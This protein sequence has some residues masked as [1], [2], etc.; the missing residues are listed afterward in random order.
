[1]EPNDKIEFNDINYIDKTIKLDFEFLKTYVF[2]LYTIPNKNKNNFNIQINPSK[3][4]LTPLNLEID[5]YEEFSI[6]LA[7]S[8]SEIHGEKKD[9]FFKLTC[10]GKTFISN[11]FSIFGG[12]FSFIHTINF[13]ESGIFKKISPPKL[14]DLN[15]FK[16]YYYLIKNFDYLILNNNIKIYFAKKFIEIFENSND[17]NFINFFYLLDSCSFDKNIF[18][19]SLV[20]ADYNFSIE[21]QITNNNTIQIENFINKLA[22]DKDNN[23]SLS[24]CENKKDEDYFL[25][26]LKFILYYYYKIKYN[27]FFN[28]LLKFEDYLEKCF[29]IIKDNSNIFNN[30]NYLKMEKIS[31]KLKNI[32]SILLI[33]DYFKDFNKKISLI[34]LNIKKLTNSTIK[35]DNV[36]GINIKKDSDLKIFEQSLKNYQSIIKQNLILLKIN[37]EIFI[38]VF[39]QINDITKLKIFR[40]IFIDIFYI[41]E[42]YYKQI[43]FEIDKII[44][45]SSLIKIK[46]NQYTNIEIINFIKFDSHLYDDDINE[47][48]YF[49]NFYQNTSQK[50]CIDIL[51]NICL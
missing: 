30:L 35:I 2:F 33:I 41:N 26:V 39:N 22:F 18:G 40:N 12:D 15:I 8:S 23:L 43:L 25:N 51:N 10:N 14:L 31:K 13:Q 28:F 16:K 19:D 46:K 37:K 29:I 7:Y 3:E 49:L 17:N 11:K 34:L 6:F 9:F 20:K 38:S 21:N 47:K 27:E 32:N 24:N 4:F 5:S 42:N 36:N 48:E 1:M 45:K 44:H 50:E